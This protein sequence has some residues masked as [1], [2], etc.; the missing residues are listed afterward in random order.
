MKTGLLWDEDVD[1]KM[2]E[3]FH[4]PEDF[5]FERI[6]LEP[7]DVLALNLLLYNEESIED[8]KVLVTKIAFAFFW[9]ERRLGKKNYCECTQ[10]AYIK[11]TWNDDDDNGDDEMLAEPSDSQGV[12]AR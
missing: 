1:K 4:L 3:D 10:F 11:P 9:N 2:D 12:R 5:V 8:A 7:A 6:R